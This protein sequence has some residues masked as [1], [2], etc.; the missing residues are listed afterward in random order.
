M[1]VG[2]DV[3]TGNIVGARRT[4]GKKRTTTFSTERNA[5]I[6][7]GKW[8]DVKNE[9]LRTRIN[10]VRL[11]DNV[12]IIGT[13]AYDYANIFGNVELRRPMA[14]G[15]LNPAEADALPILKAVI[16]AIL[17]DP[18][19]ENETCIYVTPSAPIDSEA[20]TIYHTDVIDNIL[21]SLG[22][23]PK[24]IKEAHSLAY[25]SLQDEDYTG[26]AISWGAGMCNVTVMYKGISALDFSVTKS[27]D[28]ID[29]QAARDTAK[30]VP[31][32]TSIKEDPDFSLIKKI[33]DIT[34]EQIALR[35]YYN[36]AIKNILTHIAHLFNNS[37]G[38][39]NFKAPVKIVCGGGTSMVDGFIDVF[40]KVY[41]E[42]EF[43]INIK[44]I[45]MV[46]DPL[47]AVA[48]GALSEAVIEEEE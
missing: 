44:S 39:P 27:G 40:K 37:E 14:L 20:H 1:P 18:K 13:G 8:K 28:W 48:G 25:G 46:K 47:H 36:Y 38:M 26:I 30:P 4:D 43:P 6:N 15:L 19:K 7:V 2:I 5:F 45:E 24:T 11:G 10:Y 35:S 32:I 17:G 9:L 42:L 34:R 29:Q 22:Y 33:P 21:T 31:Q 3:G 16:A 41:D 23:A 12:Y